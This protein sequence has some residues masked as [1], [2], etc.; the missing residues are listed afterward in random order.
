M[1]KNS[2]F[3]MNGV[4]EFNQFLASHRLQLESA[5]VPDLYW[6]AL[7]AKLSKQIFLYCRTNKLVID[8]EMSPLIEKD[9]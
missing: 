7:F 2:N 5:G 9:I 6:C 3:R 8:F 1:A 4:S